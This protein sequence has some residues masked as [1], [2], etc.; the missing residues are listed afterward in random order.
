[1]FGVV[2][3][4]GWRAQRLTR[5]RTRLTSHLAHEEADA[6]P[7]IG[8]IMSPRELS[9]IAKAIRGR[10]AD[11][12]VPWALAR[13]SPHVRTQ[14]LGQLPAPARLLYRRVWLPRFTRS[15]PPL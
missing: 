7:F 14:V 11:G 8:Q 13:A 12:T 4:R 6:L 10:A 15:T 5:L 2:A 3:E 1:G 9:A